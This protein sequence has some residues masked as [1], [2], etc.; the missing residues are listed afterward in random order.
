MLFRSAFITVLLCW[1]RIIVNNEITSL[2]L[3]EG[4]VIIVTGQVVS[5]GIL[6][7]N[8]NFGTIKNNSKFEYELKLK[9]LKIINSR[10]NYDIHNTIK[11][12]VDQNEEKLNFGEQIKAK[13]KIEKNVFGQV[14]YI[15]R[16]QNFEIISDANFVNKYFNN[17][18]IGR[19]HV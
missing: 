1:A 19:A 6:K 7:Q 16:V 18:Q 5:D 3:K 4:Q 2:N 14:Q 13:G 17:L 8:I 9:T 11:I 10:S 12:L 15:L